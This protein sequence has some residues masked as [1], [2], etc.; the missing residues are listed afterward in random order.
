MKRTEPV[1]AR[2]PIAADP[3]L[4]AVLVQELTVPLSR[5]IGAFPWD[6]EPPGRGRKVGNWFHRHVVLG[7]QDLYSRLHHRYVLFD[8]LDEETWRLVG[9]TRSL[10]S[11][12][13]RAEVVK[14]GHLDELAL[15]ATANSTL[16][17]VAHR[18]ARLTS[19]RRARERAGAYDVGGLLPAQTVQQTGDVLTEARAALDHPMRDLED[20]ALHVL[21]ADDH[22]R[23]WK[24]LQELAG[25]GDDF[26]DL[27]VAGAADPHRAAAWGSHFAQARATA[28]TLAAS[29][30]AT[31]SF[32]EE[33]GLTSTE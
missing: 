12:L 31:R 33:H 28:T 7:K 26:V 8:D 1:T 25:R 16:W 30:D 2:I 5:S 22:Y 13:Q 6:A 11:A 4:G 17:D 32:L 27:A 18:C 19:L 15:L 10:G 9:R 23:A 24:A 21:E 3:I 29:I 20:L 14:A